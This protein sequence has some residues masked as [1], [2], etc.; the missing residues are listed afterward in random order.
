[1]GSRETRHAASP[2]SAPLGQTNPPCAA[3]RRA[4]E[5]VTAPGRWPQ[6][7]VDNDLFDGDSDEDEEVEEDHDRRHDDDDDGYDD[8][9][10]VYDDQKTR[11]S[12]TTITRRRRRG[13]DNVM[14]ASET[15]EEPERPQVPADAKI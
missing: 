11:R 15:G 14:S 4:R 8:E 5:K 9:D 7:R 2:S 6:A 10:D 12:T 1:M 3:A 13:N